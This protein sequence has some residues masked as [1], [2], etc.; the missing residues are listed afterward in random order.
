M[1]ELS[2]P[3]EFAEHYN[4][5]IEQPRLFQDVGQLELARTQ[6]LLEW[7]LPPPPATVLDVGGGPGIYS[8]W[9]AAKGYTVH[10]ID[11]MPLHIDQAKDETKRTAHQPVSMTVGD[12]RKLAFG[13]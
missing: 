12:A 7:F 2:M 11:A 10:L 9:L 5:G 6:E 3:S 1:S 4:L 13:E 8:F